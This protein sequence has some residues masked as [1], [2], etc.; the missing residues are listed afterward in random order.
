MAR[1]GDDDGRAGIG[2]GIF[3]ARTT[4]TVE[5]FVS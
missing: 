3:R 1:G 2:I 5:I 4:E